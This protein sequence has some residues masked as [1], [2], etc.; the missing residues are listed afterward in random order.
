M[1]PISYTDTAVIDVP[2]DASAEVGKIKDGASASVLS[3]EHAWVSESGSVKKG[4]YKLPHHQVSDAGTPGAAVVAGVRNALSRL[5]QTTGIP[6]TDF[7]AIRSH[8]NKHMD[9]FNKSNGGPKNA[10]LAAVSIMVEANSHTW[11][12]RPEVLEILSD[13]H[14]TIASD[15]M[16]EE[17]QAVAQARSSSKA[18]VVQ[19]NGVAV[20]PLQGVITPT[21]SLIDLLFGG[22]GTGLLNFRSQLQAAAGSS[23]VKSIVLNIDSPGGAVDLVPEVAAEV[24]AVSEQKPVVAVA[25]TLA[26]SAAYWLASQAHEVVVTPSGAVG[27]IGVYNIHLDKSGLYEKAGVKPTIVRAGKYKVEANPSEPLSQDA[28]DHIQETVDDYYDM[29][30][31]AVASG[32][33]VGQADVQNGYGEGRVLTSARAVKVGLADRVATL[34]QTV[35]RMASGRARVRRASDEQKH[36]VVAGTTDGGLDLAS[37]SPEE[38]GRLFDVMVG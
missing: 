37:M 31:A 16:I 35:S 33:G 19:G 14:G 26:A 17:L 4:D 18:V 27:S 15:L 11:A 5:P 7:D 9:K 28:Q 2:W 22:G 24:R 8:L 3:K 25:N 6:R 20:I 1:P 36:E 30:T 21:V 29:F 34:D 23:D 12:V 32:R 38:R 13:L 10:G